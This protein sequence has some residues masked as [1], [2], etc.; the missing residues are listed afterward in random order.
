MN[1]KSTV[2]ML[3]AYLDRELAPTERDAVRAH[4]A[5][6]DRCR[7]EERDLRALKGLLLGVRAPEPRQDFELR[8]MSGL[9]EEAFRPMK[10]RIASPFFRPL[11]LGQFG[12]LAAV[13]VLA[14][15]VLVRSTG[16]EVPRAPVAERPRRMIAQNVDFDL[17]AQRGEAYEQAGDYTSGAPLLMPNPDVP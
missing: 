17:Y 9:R 3:S 1:C 8:L 13:A 11:I 7:V 6:C 15:V 12:G 5:D 14:F 4:L 2:G 16:A 10:S